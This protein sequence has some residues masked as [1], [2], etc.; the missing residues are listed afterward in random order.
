MRV[1]LLIGALLAGAAFHAGAPRA[2]AAGC[3]VAPNGSDADP[4][5]L[6]RPFAR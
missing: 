6:A 3:F 4:G 5:T 2:Q 1:P